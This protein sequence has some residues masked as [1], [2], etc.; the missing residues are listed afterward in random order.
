MSKE[1]KTM[2][3]RRELQKGSYI[4]KEEKKDPG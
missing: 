3:C 4:P 1:W 2:Q